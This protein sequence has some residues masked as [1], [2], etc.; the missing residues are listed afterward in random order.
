MHTNV[1]NSTCSGMI[2]ALDS[3]Q[4]ICCRLYLWR[5]KLDGQPAVLTSIKARC[6]AEN[7]QAQ[8]PVI[9]INS[10]GQIISAQ[11]TVPASLEGTC[12]SSKALQNL[13]QLPQVSDTWQALQ[14]NCLVMRMQK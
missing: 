10:A 1:P 6:L 14:S 12:S 3:L 7:F 2:P 4:P 5:V 13:K 8:S 11:L 9:N